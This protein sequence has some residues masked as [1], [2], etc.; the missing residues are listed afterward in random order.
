MLRQYLLHSQEQAPARKQ[1]I[2]EIES[3][4][5][6][7]RWK[8]PRF[9]MYNATCHPCK[10]CT[11]AGISLTL[12][13]GRAGSEDVAEHL[14]LHRNALAQLARQAG[15]DCLA[16]GLGGLEGAGYGILVEEDGTMH[17]A[18]LRPADDRKVC[19]RQGRVSSSGDWALCTVAS[20]T[21]SA[22]LPV[23][24][25][26]ATAVPTR[27]KPAL[28]SKPERGTETPS[29]VRRQTEIAT[30]VSD[31]A[32]APSIISLQCAMGGGEGMRLKRA[33]WCNMRCVGGRQVRPAGRTPLT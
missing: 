25:I 27:S 7:E 2:S 32:S 8:A 16:E 20:R 1:A 22:S 5:E 29:T 11:A 28:S 4:C 15:L 21:C 26:L 9:C 12:F 3:H 18:V 6:L 19:S 33:G 30:L 17:G 10:H 24:I 14:G 31:A 13:N 23:L